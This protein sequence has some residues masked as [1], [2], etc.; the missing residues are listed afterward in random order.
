MKGLAVLAAVSLIAAACGSTAAAPSAPATR[1]PTAPVI[2]TTTPA[3]VAACVVKPVTF[4]K[5]PS[6]ATISLEKG[7]TIVI[8][9]RPDKAP[10]T[11]TNFANV[12]LSGCYNG[13][14]FHRVELTPPFVIQGGDP[15]GN[16]TGGGQQPTELSDLPFVKGAIGIARGGDVKVS[17]DRQF[18]IC[19]GSCLHLNNLYTNFGLV[20]DGQS[21]ADAVR[22]G[23]KIKT[24]TVE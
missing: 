11:V 8:A 15:L 12:S 18:F 19:I 21:V 17:N 24:I 9:L 10:S 1:L 14:T 5:A 13:L 2:S 3:P 6:K 22:V 4:V 20:T 23:D 16:G 7:G